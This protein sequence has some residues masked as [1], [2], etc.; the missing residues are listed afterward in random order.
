[1]KL[2][3]QDN[4]LS[5]SVITKTGTLTFPARSLYSRGGGGGCCGENNRNVEEEGIK[6]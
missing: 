2:K 5:S 4:L 6:L 3:T 1:M